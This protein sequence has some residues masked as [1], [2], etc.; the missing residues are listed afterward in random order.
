MEARANILYSHLPQRPPVKYP[1]FSLS[2]RGWGLSISSTA[3]YVVPLFLIGLFNCYICGS[4]IFDID[5]CHD[6][7]HVLN[8]YW[9]QLKETRKHNLV[10]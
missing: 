6:M 5:I 9:L 1:L 2:G 10:H 3:I 4:S 8:W 7:R